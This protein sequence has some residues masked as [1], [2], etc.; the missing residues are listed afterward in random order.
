MGGFAGKVIRRMGG[1][2]QNIPGGEISKAW[3]R[4]HR[5]RR[6]IGPDDDLKLGFNKVAPFYYY[7]GWWDGG[8]NLE[9]Y[10]NQ[11]LWKSLSAENRAIVRAAVQAHV[12][13]QARR[14]STCALKQLVA[15]KTKVVPSRKR[16]WTPR[17]K[18]PWACMPTSTRATQTG[19]RSTLT[20]AISSAIKSSGSRF[21]RSRFDSFMSSQSSDCK[22]V[23]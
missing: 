12:T 1:V 8:L 6:W 21:A 14:L 13:T 16:C 2:P 7:P 20:S 18:P 19:R 17:S 23:V 15:A 10:V 4:H 11:R 22:R 9:F 5:R 3:K